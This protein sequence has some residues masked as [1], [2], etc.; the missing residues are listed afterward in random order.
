MAFDVR[1]APQNIVTSG[2][3]ALA[4]L[5]SNGQLSCGGGNRRGHGQAIQE[6][7]SLGSLALVDKHLS[8]DDHHGCEQQ[9]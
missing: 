1:K 4:A 8:G 5:P 3:T 6:H 7:H 2:S 9:D